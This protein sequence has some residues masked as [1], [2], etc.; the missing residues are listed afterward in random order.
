[1]PEFL[2]CLTPRSFHSLAKLCKE[3]GWIIERPFK[4]KI[5]VSGRI[6]PIE[7]IDK[8]IRQQPGRDHAPGDIE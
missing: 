5:E 7:E 1:M 4:R 8:L 3:L 6:E 2:D